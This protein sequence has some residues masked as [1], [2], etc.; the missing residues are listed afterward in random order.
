MTAQ[1]KPYTV[2]TL[3]Q[4]WECSEGLVRKMIERGE[5]SSFRLGT[6]IR[7]PASEVA[8]IECHTAS[9][10]SEA[11]MPSSGERMGSDADERST[12]RIGRARKPRPADYGK[13]ATILH[14]R[15]AG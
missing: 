3:A 14:G 6:L 2:P 8:K 5:L 1:A 9:N 10:D 11:D 13:P 12:P 15:W 4:R 7:I